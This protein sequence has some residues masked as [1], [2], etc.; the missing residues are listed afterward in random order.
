V[1][2]IGI[3]YICVSGIQGTEEIMLFG[4]AVMEATG[5]N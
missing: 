2:I 4:A 5:Y 3:S 1:A